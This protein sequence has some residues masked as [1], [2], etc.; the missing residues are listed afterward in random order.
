MDVVSLTSSTVKSRHSLVAKQA[1]N[2]WH[3]YLKKICNNIKEGIRTKDFF[4]LDTGVFLGQLLVTHEK[5]YFV[6][7][8][9]DLAIAEIKLANEEIKINDSTISIPKQY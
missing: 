2:E 5:I 1:Y 6:D 7:S 4:I 9:T 8:P 3:Q